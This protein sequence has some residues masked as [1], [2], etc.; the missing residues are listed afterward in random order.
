MSRWLSIAVMLALFVSA[1]L[2]LAA[3]ESAQDGATASQF[4]KPY[5]GSIFKGRRD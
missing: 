3:C 2:T 5:D 1:G 4:D